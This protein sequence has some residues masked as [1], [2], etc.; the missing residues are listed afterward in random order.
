MPK[1]AGSLEQFLMFAVV[2]LADGAHG[3]AIRQE[4]ERTADRVV[5]HGALYTTMDRL[6]RRGLV[7]SWIGSESP[8]TGG[9]KRKFY[10]LEPAGARALREG[11]EG[12]RRLAEG[13]L[14]RLV[15]VEGD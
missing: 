12:L 6:E 1:V 7:S 13:T 10:R 15:A 4:V 14:D 2:R 5:S 9:R 8:E 11:Y 3:L